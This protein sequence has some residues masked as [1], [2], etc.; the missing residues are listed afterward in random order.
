MARKIITGDR[1]AQWRQALV[2]AGGHYR[3]L[4][5]FKTDRRYKYDNGEILLVYSRAGED[6]RH[7]LY[8]CVMLEEQAEHL[9]VFF[10]SESSEIAA[11]IE[12]IAAHRPPRGP[13]AAAPAIAARGSRAASAEQTT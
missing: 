8:G 7:P 1:S 3:L 5:S 13:A 4:R 2:A 6:D 9:F 11:D 12:A 10:M